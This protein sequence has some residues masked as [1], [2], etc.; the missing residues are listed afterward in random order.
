MNAWDA[1]LN[2]ITA[3]ANWKVVVAFFAY[4]MIARGTPLLSFLLFG[5]KRPA[6]SGFTW[7]I[8]CT[9]IDLVALPFFLGSTVLIIT[10]LGSD[11]TFAYA[12]EH[13][14]ELFGAALVGFVMT[15][16]FSAIP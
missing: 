15:L 9:L 4:L 11:F 8:V 14:W 2:G 12:I 16:V 6:F 10:K 7:M 5:G 1:V 3:F 13:V